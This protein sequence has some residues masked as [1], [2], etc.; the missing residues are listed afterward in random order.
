MKMGLYVCGCYVF[1]TPPHL[2]D[3]VATV[4]SPAGSGESVK[5]EGNPN[6]VFFFQS[7]RPV[8]PEEGDKG[9]ARSS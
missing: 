7:G 2:A 6:L 5:L 4:T 8:V 1:P 9:R 3:V